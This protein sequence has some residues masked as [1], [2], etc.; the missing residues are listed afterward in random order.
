MGNDQGTENTYNYTAYPLKREIVKIYNCN[1][2]QKPF[3]FLIYLNVQKFIC[4][5]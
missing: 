4:L 1:P 3:G 5:M 2:K